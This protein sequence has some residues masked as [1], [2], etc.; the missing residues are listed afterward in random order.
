MKL[1]F[2]LMIN[3]VVARY[4]VLPF[5]ILDLKEIVDAVVVV[6]V[7]AE[8][9]NALGTIKMASDHDNRGEVEQY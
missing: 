6:I 4:I 8:R 2:E 9:R 3:L 5:R 1:L 7:V